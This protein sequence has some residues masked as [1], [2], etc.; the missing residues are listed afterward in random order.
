MS[1]PKNPL[2]GELF[3]VNDKLKKLSLISL[4][5]KIGFTVLGAS[6]HEDNKYGLPSVVDTTIV[7]WTSF[8]TNS[9]LFHDL[10]KDIIKSL[11][12]ALEIEKIDLEYRIGTEGNP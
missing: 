1:K 4:N 7:S 10:A 11:I 6:G 5:D 12:K 3:K 2:A 9:G 8:D